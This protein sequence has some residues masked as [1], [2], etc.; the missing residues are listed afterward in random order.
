MGLSISDADLGRYVDGIFDGSNTFE[1]I[2]ASLQKSVA[3]MLPQFSDRINAGETLQE[4]V[5][6][7]RNMIASY[8]EIDSNEIGFGFGSDVKAD[9]LLNAALFGKN[10]EPM[11]MY[12]LQKAIKQDSRWQKTSNARSEYA[13]LTTG[14][15]R[16]LGV[17]L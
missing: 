15:L 16:K 7:Y 4:I 8:L 6:P 12:E 9:P 10:N 3:S 17:G 2:Q 14:L 13:N 11:S 5:S 1:N